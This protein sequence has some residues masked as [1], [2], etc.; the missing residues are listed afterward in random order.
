M[1]RIDFSSARMHQETEE[2]ILHKLRMS[3]WYELV[4]DYKYK[5]Y[6]FIHDFS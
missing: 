6:D 5:N 3:V 2:E 4:A 1:S